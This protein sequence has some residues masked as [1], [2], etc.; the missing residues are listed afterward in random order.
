MAEN[1]WVRVTIFKVERNFRTQSLTRSF[2]FWALRNSQVCN[3][4]LTFIYIK[5]TKGNYTF[6]LMGKKAWTN[7]DTVLLD[8]TASESESQSCP[9]LQLHGL[10]SLRNFPGQNTGVGSQPFPPPGDLP[11]P[12]IKPRSS[13]LQAGF[14]TSWA[15][16]EALIWQEQILKKKQTNNNYLMLKLSKRKCPSSSKAENVLLS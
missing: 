9:T 10:D 15:T 11:N 6:I 5:K 4:T 16:R 8:L 13:P 2:C 3:E 7:Q 12:A 1:K 14:F